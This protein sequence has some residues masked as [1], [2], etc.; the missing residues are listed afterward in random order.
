[1][2]QRLT[3]WLIRLIIVTLAA[4]A[5]ALAAPAQPVPEIP[6]PT[7]TPTLTLTPTKTPTASVTPTASTT[8]TSTPTPTATPTPTPTCAPGRVEKH[9]YYSQVSYAEEQYSIYL[10][11]CYDQRSDRYPVA[12]LLHGWPYDN[13]H[14]DDLGVDEAAEKGIQAGTVPP[15]ILVLPRGGEW[16]FVGTSGG[17]VSFESQIIMDLLPHIDQVYRTIPSPDARAIGGIS[18]GGV[19]SL[20][21]AMM[22]PDL[23][24]TVGAHS[25]ALAVNL[26]GPSHDPFYLLSRPGVSGLRIYLDSGDVDW[27]RSS[28]QS[29]HEALGTA[30]I[31]NVYTQHTGGHNDALWSENVA[32][33]LLFYTADWFGLDEGKLSPDPATNE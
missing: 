13:R 23:F 20:E 14:W 7:L 10:P 5:I 6:A 30:G 32:E 12:Y 2:Q 21:I 8:P 11:P 9:V 18:R 31:A 17:A 27:T 28:T 22:H 19:W 3:T 15:C 29:L 16:L 4:G 1:V 24:S 33:Y 25:P 26:A